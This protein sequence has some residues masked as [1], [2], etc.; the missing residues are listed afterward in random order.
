MVTGNKQLFRPYTN[1]TQYIVN[2]PFSQVS[3]KGLFESE[4]GNNNHKITAH[5]DTVY[6]YKVATIVIS[7]T[8]NNLS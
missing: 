7:T 4:F 2:V 1:Y 3:E 8:L 5:T 6:S